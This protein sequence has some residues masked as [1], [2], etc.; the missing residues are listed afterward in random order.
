MNK[1]IK[2]SVELLITASQ[3]PYECEWVVGQVLKQLGAA[4]VAQGCVVEVKQKVMSQ[5][6][7]DNLEGQ[8][9]REGVIARAAGKRM[10]RKRLEMMCRQ[11]LKSVIILI[12]GDDLEVFLKQWVGSIQWVGFSP[13]RPGHKRQ[14]WLVGIKAIHSHSHRHS[15]SVIEGNISAGDI[16]NSEIRYE[17][18]RSQGPGG[19]H[20]NTTESAVR[21]IHV[22]TGLT[23]VVQD[24]R[25]QW[26]NKKMA[27]TR[28]GEK[29]QEMAQVNFHRQAQLELVR[30]N[31][32]KVFST[33][34]FE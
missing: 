15:D 11:C 33:S 28:L 27:K 7:I 23:V 26:Q 8:R 16:A 12:E 5:L 31:A 30:G 24:T 20:V 18:M 9:L 34:D 17:T 10:N 2:N 22:Q 25:S 32:V 14:N 13:F 21:A 1:K 3:G 19:Q 4:A 29:L 6:A